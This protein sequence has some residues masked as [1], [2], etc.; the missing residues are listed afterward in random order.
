[1][2]ILGLE[3]EDWKVLTES[4]LKPLSALQPSAIACLNNSHLE[5]M[6]QL[7]HKVEQ[8]FRSYYLL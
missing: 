8:I 5:V 4:S 3:I 1:M 6:S 2:N 7:T